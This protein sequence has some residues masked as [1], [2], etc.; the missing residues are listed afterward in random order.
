MKVTLYTPEDFKQRRNH[1]ERLLREQKISI[2]KVLTG[3]DVKKKGKQ[4][5]KIKEKEIQREGIR[6]LESENIYTGN[7]FQDAKSQ[8]GNS[9]P[10]K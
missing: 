9:I 10:E 8:T 2:P 1:R 5:D 3:N 6:R 7:S 4:T